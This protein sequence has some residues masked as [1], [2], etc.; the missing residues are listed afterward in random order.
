MIIIRKLFSKKSNEDLGYKIIKVHLVGGTK[1]ISELSDKQLKNVAAYNNLSKEEKK[2]I[3][4]NSTILGIPMSIGSGLIGAGISKNKKV[5]AAIGASIGA[6]T[7]AGMA[8]SGHKLHK[9]QAA[10]AEKEIEYRKNNK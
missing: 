10:A 8:I 7:M 9:K 1:K 3:V 4:K 6:S 2:N 5:G